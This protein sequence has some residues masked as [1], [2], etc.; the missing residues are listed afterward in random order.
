MPLPIDQ[1][2]YTGADVDWNNRVGTEK[3]GPG[4]SG[5]PQENNFQN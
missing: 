4:G 2:I 3:G 5:S 1:C